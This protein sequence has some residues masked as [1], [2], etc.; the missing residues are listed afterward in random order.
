[1][2]EIKFRAWNKSRKAWEIGVVIGLD[3][4]VVGW[5]NGG[6]D[7]ELQQ[8]TGRKDR[9]GREIYEG[10]ILKGY[11]ALR[12]CYWDDGSD[13]CRGGWEFIEHR[14]AGGSVRDA[15]LEVIGNI[16]ENSELLKE[17]E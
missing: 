11:G 2:R 8:Y 12:E 14:S 5:S 3:G 10:D 6:A 17:V 15:D 7:I 4:R 1:M 16:Y 13:G 9:N